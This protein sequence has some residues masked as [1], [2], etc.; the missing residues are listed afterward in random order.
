MVR[1]GYHASHGQFAPG[2]LLTLVQQAQAAGFDCAKSSD[3]F[4]PLSKRQSQ[5]RFTWSWLGARRH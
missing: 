4:H 5:S 2:H 3:H 1:I